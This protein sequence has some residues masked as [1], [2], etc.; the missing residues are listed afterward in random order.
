MAKKKNYFGNGIAPSC[1]YCQFGDRSKDG[2]K[3]VCEKSGL[4]ETDSSCKK[5]VYDPIKRIPKKQHEI[6][7]D[8]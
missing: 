6:E 8:D 1:S 3:V 4:V 2:D 5:W 7:Q